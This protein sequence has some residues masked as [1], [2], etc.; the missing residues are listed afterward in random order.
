MNS[1]EIFDTVATHLFKQGEQARGDRIL[2]RCSYRTDEGLTCAVGCL[3]QDYYDPG[4][5][6]MHS[7]DI[8]SVYKEFKDKLPEW[9][10]THMVLLQTLQGIHDETLNWS[11]PD[12]MKEALI[13]LA[14]VKGLDY[15]ILDKFERFGA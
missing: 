14:E 4:M 1:Q 5:D 7:S 15:S 10:L 9:I 3:I 2:G 11:S 6:N 8:L 13:D 12:M